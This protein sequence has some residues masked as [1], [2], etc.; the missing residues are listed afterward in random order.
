M[1]EENTES[2]N[3]NGS[4]GHWSLEYFAPGPYT[5]NWD[6]HN[7][8]PKDMPDIPR[9]MIT[10]S[11]YEIVEQ[12][13]FEKGNLAKYNKNKITMFT[14]KDEKG[15]PH[16]KSEDAN[17]Y[18]KKNPMAQWS[19]W[20]HELGHYSDDKHYGIIGLENTPTNV[21]RFN[22]FTERKSMAIQYL[23][24]ADKYIRMK[25]DGITE[26]QYNNK[27][28][29]LDETLKICP[30][31]K[32]VLDKYGT[33]LDDQQ[34]SREIVKA[35]EN[36]LDDYN[37]RDKNYENQAYEAYCKSYDYNRSYGLSVRVD[38]AKNE[39]DKYETTTDSILKQVNI[40]ERYI[41]LT[42]CKDLIDTMK[43]KDVAALV[44]EKNDK[45][46]PYI[47]SE[48]LLAVND[49]LE[50]K[51]MTDDTEKE[52][53]IVENFLG[54]TQKDETADA[55]LRDVFLK[56]SPENQTIV[57]SDGSK[58]D[59]AQKKK[60]EKTLLAKQLH[61]DAEKMKVEQKEEIE[62]LKKQNTAT[63]VIEENQATQTQSAESK[64]TTN[65][66]QGR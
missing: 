45:K 46:H 55:G 48:Q 62:A 25:N 41:D 38:M 40:G 3:Q 35:A 21:T 24:V 64:S 27:S 14:V 50:K 22:N 56:T 32:E 30:G 58:E 8:Q 37:T 66:N 44:I 31:L 13:K 12:D 42:H 15:Q 17:E 2:T 1:S 6:R 54:T 28:I 16:H 10:R 23:G 18:I 36:F 33:N 53:Y 59:F 49:Y 29:P 51:G 26:F 34:T 65:Q 19:M 60:I 61:T 52:M 39:K 5:I 43:E 47:S 20:L 9:K 57:Y 7:F 63:K 11:D 4:I